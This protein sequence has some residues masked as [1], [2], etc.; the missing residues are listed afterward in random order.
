[1]MKNKAFAKLSDWMSD[2]YAVA[3]LA[4]KKEQELLETLYKSA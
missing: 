1:V 2:F 3:R 4:L